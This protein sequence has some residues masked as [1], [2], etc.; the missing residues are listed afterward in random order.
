MLRKSGC[1]VILFCLVANA[2]AGLQVHLDF[3]SKNTVETW[4]YEDLSGNG[5]HGNEEGSFYNY[6]GDLSQ[7]ADMWE[8]AVDGREGVYAYR[9]ALEMD[10]DASMLDNPQ[11][12]G[13]Y[14]HTSDT[15]GAGR[16]D[17]NRVKLISTPTLAADGGLT[18]ALWVNP[19]TVHCRE[20]T[21]TN[22]NP[23]CDFG[24]L[25][26]LGAYGNAPIMSMEL[27]ADKH[28]H[29]WIEGDGTD[30]QYEIIGTGTVA[31][32]TWTHV[33]I[34]FDRA[35]DVVTTYINGQVDSTTA[36]PLVGDGALTFTN[37]LIGGGIMTSHYETFMGSLDD[38]RI[39]DEVLTQ[40]QIAAIVPE[41][42]TL[43]LLGLG[44]FW[45]W[46]RKK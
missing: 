12:D 30:T 24:H 31:A 4:E 10:Y 17:N 25:V 5:H 14:Y 43:V 37:G 19:E 18:I 46:R 7:Y 34:T 20:R 1:L 45:A 40:S 16:W 11:I 39:Y 15:S 38:V 8:A 27:D 42:A 21:K 36:I 22:N 41:P 33:A 29:G 28:V 32:N 2:G 13:L 6:N 44:G 35:N 26:V 3:T 9:Y 23:D